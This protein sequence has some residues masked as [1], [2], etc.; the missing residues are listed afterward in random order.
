MCMICPEC[1]QKNKLAKLE[2][3]RDIL[4][5]MEYY[6]CWVCSNYYGTNIKKKEGE[7]TC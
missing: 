7:G 4:S 6:Y 3:Q 5:Q 2:R 1:K